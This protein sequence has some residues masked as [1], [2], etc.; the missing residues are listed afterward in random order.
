MLYL[1][2]LVLSISGWPFPEDFIAIGLAHHRQRDGRAN[3]DLPSSDASL[4][5]AND[6]IHPLLVVSETD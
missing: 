5:I 3:G 6:F 1:L 2:N 4:V